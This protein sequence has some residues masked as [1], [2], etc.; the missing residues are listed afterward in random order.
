M[1][2][3]WITNKQTGQHILSIVKF[4]Q[5]HHPKRKI[6]CVICSLKN[7]DGYNNVISRHLNSVS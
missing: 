1:W 3:F 2:Q 6:Q 5:K 4:E 7:I